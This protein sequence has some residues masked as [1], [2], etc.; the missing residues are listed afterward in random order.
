LKPRSFESLDEE[1]SPESK[2]VL[3][4]LDHEVNLPQ[5]RQPAVQSKQEQSCDS[6]QFLED[7]QNSP[8]SDQDSNGL[9]NLTKELASNCEISG[10]STSQTEVEEIT[11]KVRVDLRNLAEVR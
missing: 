3:E 1:P 4:S 9:S 2:E 11:N 8:V 10:D 5:L 6:K 7:V